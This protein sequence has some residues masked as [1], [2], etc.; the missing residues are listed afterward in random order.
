[1]LS[2]F[3]NMLEPSRGALRLSALLAARTYPKT[4]MVR[5]HTPT[6]MIHK[7]EIEEKVRADPNLHTITRGEG[8]GGEGLANLT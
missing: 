5:E 1:M 7:R 3:L 4:S 2:R 8:M 6:L